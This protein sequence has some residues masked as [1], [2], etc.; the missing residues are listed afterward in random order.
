MVQGRKPK[1]KVLKLAEGNRRQ[2]G[3]ASIKDDPQGLGTPRVPVHLTA[4]ERKIWAD[5]VGSLPDG[6][7][8][9]ADDLI[10]ERM[11]VA[12]ARWRAAT[13][14]IRKSGYLVQS[15][16]GP[17]RNPLLVVQSVAA[18]EMHAA[19]SELGLSPASRARL[20]APTARDDDPMAL[21]L[22]MDGDEDWPA[23]PRTKQ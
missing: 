4:D 19:G 12:A 16:Q 22:G 15:P 9:R 14:T 2:R 1:P 17:V 8:S 3:L 13:E 20:A 21:L 18:R 7:L 6:L 5:I 11:A 23:T 10:L